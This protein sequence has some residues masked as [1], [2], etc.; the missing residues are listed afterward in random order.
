MKNMKRSTF[1]LGVLVVFVFMTMSISGTTYSADKPI[2]LSFSTILPVQYPFTKAMDAWGKEVENRTAGRVKVTYYH[3]GS[4]VDA[5]NAYEGVINGITD[6]ALTW[7]SYS[8][9]RFPLAEVLDIPGFEFNAIAVTHVYN[10]WYRKFKPKEFDDTHMLYLFGST[11][12]TF[13]TKKPIRTQQDF[14]GSRIRCI[15]ISCNVV[16]ALGGTPVAM[17][18]PDV[19]DALQKGIIDGAVGN[20]NELK[21]WRMAEVASYTTIYSRVGYLSASIVIM[22]KKKWDSL[23]SDIKKIVTEVSLDW[24]EY[25]GKAMN[26]LEVEGI[27]Y[28]KEKGHKF[29]A[30]SSEEGRRWEK[31]LEPLQNDYVKRM[32]QKNL[33]GKEALDYRNQLVEKYN[34]THPSI[35]KFE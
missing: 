15:G 29:I 26:T 4:L 32:T 6:I 20:P 23:P 24:E 12:G 17:P 31:A 11:P 25:I 5:A 2:E 19:Y 8:R 18:K 27:T 7:P 30:L 10:D 16:E 3:A 34:K 22:N 21:Y 14:K 9:G 1:G 35:Y 28:G 13:Y 33:P